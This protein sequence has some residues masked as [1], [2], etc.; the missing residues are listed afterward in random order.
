MAKLHANGIDL[1]Y[2]IHGPED[3]KPFLLICGFTRSLA[4]WP[5]SLIAGLTESGYK[6]IIFDNRDIGLSHQFDDFGLPDM[7]KLMG[8]LADGSAHE[9]A[10]YVLTD[11]ARDAA[12]LL[13][14]LSATPAVVMGT[15]MGG[16]ICQL[17]ALNHP[18]CV[19]AIIPTMTTSGDPSIRMST[20]EAQA[21]LSNRPESPTREAVVERAIASNMVIGSGAELRAS[22]DQLAEGAGRDFDRAYRPAGI[23]RQLAAMTAQPRWHHRLETLDL[24]TLVLHGEVDTLIMRENGKD[25][26]KRIPGAVFVEIAGWGH[27]MPPKSVPILLSHII[28]FADAVTD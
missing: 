13:K 26:A 6:V 15:S 3:G 11:M 4:S 7:K 17:L 8:G 19:T 25:V 16:M 1:E 14:A 2:K 28:P 24:P 10:P 20:P 21:V 18:E 12:E 9:H 22:D 5:P 23:A 27:D